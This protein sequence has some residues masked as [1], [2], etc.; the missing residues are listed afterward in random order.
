MNLFL[1]NRNRVNEFQYCCVV[2]AAGETASN[3]NIIP[4]VDDTQVF[5]FVIWE[6]KRKLP[7]DSMQ[8]TTISHKPR[9]LFA[10]E[11][12]RNSCHLNMILCLSFTSSILVGFLYFRCLFLPPQSDCVLLLTIKVNRHFLCVR[13]LTLSAAQFKAVSIIHM[14]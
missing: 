3:K 4:E 13:R 8:S 12:M 5:V 2:R 9:R 14:R 11:M 1:L 7:Q 10:D 6:G